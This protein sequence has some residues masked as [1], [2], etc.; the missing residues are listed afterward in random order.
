MKPIKEIQT[1]TTRICH[2]TPVRM[3]VLKKQK[4]TGVDKVVEKVKPWY[5][6]GEN[7]T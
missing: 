5:A 3:A 2:L 6:T 1:K 4:T 7:A